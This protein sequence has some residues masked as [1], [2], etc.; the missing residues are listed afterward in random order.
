MIEDY[1]AQGGNSYVH[2][3]WE[4][5]CEWEVVSTWEEVIE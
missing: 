4:E 5:M 1:A 2:D 3:L